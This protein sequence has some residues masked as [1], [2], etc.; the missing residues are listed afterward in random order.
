MKFLTILAPAALL[1]TYLQAAPVITGITTTE[2][3]VELTVQDDGTFDRFRIEA[4]LDLEAGSW[5]SIT[6]INSTSLGGN[7]YRLTIAK[8]LADREFYRVIGAFLGTTLDLDGDGISNDRETSNENGSVTDPNKFDTD[9]D[10]FSDATEIALGTNPT[11]RNDFPELAHLPAIA[12]TEAISAIEE[13][14]GSYTISLTASTPYTGQVSLSVNARSSAVQGTDYTSVPTS[15]FMSGG[16][17]TFDIAIIDDLEIRPSRQLILDIT[18]DPIGDAYRTGG[19]V[20]HLLNITDNDAYWFGSLRDELTERSFRVCI[21]RDDTTTQAE[22]V[23]GQDDGLPD[24]D[25][26]SSS[27]STGLIPEKNLAG[28]D[29]TEWPASSINF[30]LSTPAFSASV[31]DLPSVA[32]G[33]ITDPLA[34]TITL[35]ATP[36]T[37]ATHTVLSNLVS[38]TYTEQIKHA[39]DPGTTYLNK[40][41]TGVFS[42]IRDV[43]PAPAIN[44]PFN[45]LN[46]PAE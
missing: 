41:L 20:T 36:N 4:T 40:I 39:T 46:D 33:I 14:Q 38:G 42:M 9:D 31:E 11:D 35:T 23:S 10:G 19:R 44:S 5:G 24:P 37:D 45:P 2:T 34:R 15:V 17:A 16:T 1:G 8:T 22:F 21:L 7:R 12:F 25:T 32:N 6:G 30:D 29:Q 27:L 28:D 18:K 13:G 26:G 3:E 43:A